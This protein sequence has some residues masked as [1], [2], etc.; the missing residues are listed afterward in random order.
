MY[1]ILIINTLL[2]AFGSIHAQFASEDSPPAQLIQNMQSRDKTTL[3]GM[4]NIIIDPLENGYYNH[5]YQPRSDGF[6]I[7]AKPTSPA[8]LIEYDF[9]TDYQLMVPGDWNTQLEKLYYYEGTIWYK[10]NFDYEF[11]PNELTYLYFEAVNYEALVYLNGQ[12][13]GSHRGGY[14]P[15]QFDVTGKLQQKG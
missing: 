7:N 1:K 8:D 5:R 12:L 9:D 6:F 14:T 2:F 3:D 15:F 11:K 13:L 10:K 4:W